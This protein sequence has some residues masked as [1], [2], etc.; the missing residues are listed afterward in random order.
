M[1]EHVIVLL[2]FVFALALTHVLSSATELIAA[3]DR[4][5][6]SGRLALWMANA[7][8][9]LLVNWLGFW[10]LSAVKRWTVGEITLQFSAA[11]IEYFTCSL[12]SMRPAAGERVDMTVFFE[13]QR[14]PIML[15]FLALMVVSMVQNYVDRDHSAGLASTDWIV[16]NLI[17]APMG[18]LVVL[19]G[20]A[21]PLWLQ[22]AAGLVFLA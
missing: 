15:A 7:V 18:L 14:R 19:A 5:R 22:W 6:F 11:V 21:R 8:I 13:R 1:F 17:I 3:R 12:V 9:G 10:G 4:L 20:W 2:S 16:E